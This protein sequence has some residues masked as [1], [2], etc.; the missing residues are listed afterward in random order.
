M[1]HVS[2]YIHHHIAAVCPNCKTLCT[3]DLGEEDD[4]YGM[5]IKCHHCSW[6]FS[7]GEQR[8]E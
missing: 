3:E 1:E 8:L 7:L 6:T 4:A 2:Y 5:Q